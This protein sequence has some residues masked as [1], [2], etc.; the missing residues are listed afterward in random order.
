ML[1][2]SPKKICTYMA[3]YV[4]IAILSLSLSLPQLLISLVITML[5]LVQ[6]VV[7]T[8]IGSRTS[9]NIFLCLKVFQHSSFHQRKSR[10]EILL[11]ET[12]KEILWRDF[13]DSSQSQIFPGTSLRSHILSRF[14]EGNVS[15]ETPQISQRQKLLRN[16]S[17]FL[18]ADWKS[19]LLHSHVFTSFI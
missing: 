17:P 8:R 16:V 2:I 18:A 12:A 13:S 9:K 14:P 11:L 19:P 6:T 7:H 5:C 1:S 3:T 15:P 10:G 4:D